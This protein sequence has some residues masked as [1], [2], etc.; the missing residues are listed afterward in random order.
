MEREGVAN[1]DAVELEKEF[2]ATLFDKRDEEE[3]LEVM[4]RE[5]EDWWDGLWRK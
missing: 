3:V 5:V 1:V 4:G 2:A